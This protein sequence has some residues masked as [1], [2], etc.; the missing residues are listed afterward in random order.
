MEAD[1]GIDVYVFMTTGQIA[2]AD[3]AHH[4]IPLK[5]DWNKRN[6]IENLMSLSHDTHSIIEKKYKKDKDK[7]QAELKEMLK[8]FREMIRG[9]AV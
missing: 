9:G 1:G 7:M 2:L 5:D 3:T 6:D 4:I 8:Q